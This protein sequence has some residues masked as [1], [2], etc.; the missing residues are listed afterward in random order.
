MLGFKSLLK[1]D[2]MSFNST[3]KALCKRCGMPIENNGSGTNNDGSPS[4]EYCRVCYQHGSFSN[5]DVTMAHMADQMANILVT[6]VSDT[7]TLQTLLRNL[8]GI[9]RVGLSQ[10]ENLEQIFPFS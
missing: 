8:Q 7:E 4:Q 1:G 9:L 6:T 5:P 10:N 2:F 3:H